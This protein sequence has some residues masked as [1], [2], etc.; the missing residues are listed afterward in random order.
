M[1]YKLKGL[2]E[3]VLNSF[4]PVR[5][6]YCDIVIDPQRYACGEC[7][8][9]FPEIPITTYIEGGIRCVAPFLYKD[10]YAEAVKRFK[11]NS[12]AQYA[13]AFAFALVN[14]LGSSGVDLNFD[15][16]TCVPMHKEQRIKRGY[17]Q[18]QL[19]ARHCA[20]LMQTVYIDALEKFRQNQVQHTLS[21]AERR[22]NVKGV[23]RALN[24]E[25]LKDKRVLI[26]DDIVT[27]GSTL[28]E[29]TKIL[30]KSGCGEIC[31]AVVCCAE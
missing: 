12:R 9:N 26:I 27:T 10:S 31:C 29:C 1:K 2:Y 8:K 4:F 17:N 15:Y 25:K 20:E 6:P 3:F 16:I 19:L 13:K 22:K 18:S 11:F 30:S 28:A 23:Y 5:C 14:A 7:S 24:K 21:G